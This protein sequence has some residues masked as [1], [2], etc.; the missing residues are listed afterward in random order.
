MKTVRLQIEGMTC[1]H[2]VA[3]VNRALDGI[4][5]ITDL[6]VEI[7]RAKFKIPEE[8]DLG[9]VIESIEDLGYSVVNI[10]RDSG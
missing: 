4:D 2:C 3:A 10:E 9:P 1:Q 8:F 7:G 5:G 6:I